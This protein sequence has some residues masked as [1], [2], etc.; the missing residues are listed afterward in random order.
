MATPTTSVDEGMTNGE[1]APGSAALT[2]RQGWIGVGLALLA[3]YIIWGSTYLA[4]RY[5]IEGFPPFLMAAIRFLIA[6]TLL[7]GFHLARREPLPSRKQVAGAAVVGLLL[8]VGG[9]G[10]VAFAEQTVTSSVAALAIATVPLWAVL[11][12]RIWGRWPSKPEWIGLALGFLGIVL[13]NMGGNL[14]A[15]PLGAVLLLLAAASWAFGSVLSQH[16]PL[17]ASG[18]MSSAVEM[19]AAGAVLAVM[20][21]VHGDHVA[22]HIPAASWWAMGFLLIFGS[23]VAFSAYVFLLRRVRPALATSYAYVN[24]IVAV[25]LGAGLAGEAIT[26]PEMLALLFILTGVVLVILGREKKGAK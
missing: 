2:S 16:L 18:A 6:G 19:L 13:L 3:L 26:W 10:T 11:F 25:A 22:A 5:A 12:A 15:N 8:L 21:Q 4:M 1:H 7:F 17:P 24:P 23:L 20:S 9:N 14:H